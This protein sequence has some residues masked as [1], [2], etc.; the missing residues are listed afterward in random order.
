[1]EMIADGTALVN[2]YG[3]WAKTKSKERAK[4]PQSLRDISILREPLVTRP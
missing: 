1:M 4:L 2:K 3:A